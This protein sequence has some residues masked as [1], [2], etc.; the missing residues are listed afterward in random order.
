MEL[1]I[2]GR[3]VDTR[4]MVFFFKK[5]FACNFE[6]GSPNLI[7]L[8]FGSFSFSHSHDTPRRKLVAIHTYLQCGTPQP[9]SLHGGIGS[10]ILGMCVNLVA[11][12]QSLEVC[13]LGRLGGA[14]GHFSTHHISSG[15]G[16]FGADSE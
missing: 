4:I 13:D 12:W 10:G 1:G 3:Y 5:I 7:V 16:D 9:F 6:M 15:G 2:L 11:A 8:F 14:S